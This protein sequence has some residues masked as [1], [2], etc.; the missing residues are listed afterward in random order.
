VIDLDKAVAGL[1]AI[2]PDKDPEVAKNLLE[3]LIEEIRLD[4][5]EQSDYRFYATYGFHV[6]QSWFGNEPEPDA[7]E[8]FVLVEYDYPEVSDD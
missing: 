3:H 5:P 2:Y 4:P 7:I 8:V 1:L 6:Q